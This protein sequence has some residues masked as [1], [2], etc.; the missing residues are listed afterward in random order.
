MWNDAPPPEKTKLTP[1][2]KENNSEKKKTL[3]VLFEFGDFHLING[4]M[5]FNLD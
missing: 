5:V 1:R 3:G 4:V 2:K